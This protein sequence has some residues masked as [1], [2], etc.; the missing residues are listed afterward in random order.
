MVFDAI[1]LSHHGSLRNTSPEL[2]NLIDSPRYFISSNGERHNHPDVEV[3]KAIVD[4]PTHLHRNLYFNYSTPASRWLKG[5]TSKSGAT[6]SVHE[7]LQSAIPLH[8]AHDND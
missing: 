8:P 6:F 2:L 7:N 5:Y 3:I 4:R 1:K